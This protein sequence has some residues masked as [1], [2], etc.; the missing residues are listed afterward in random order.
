MICPRLQRIFRSF[1]ST[2]ELAL[3][4]LPIEREVKILA[5]DEEIFWLPQNGPLPDL[6]QIPERC[7]RTAKL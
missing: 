2:T 6:V 7:H 5:A 3:Y 1:V 4:C